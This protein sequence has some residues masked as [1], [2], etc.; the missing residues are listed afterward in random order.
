VKYDAVIVGSGPAGSVTAYYAA[1]N[2]ANVLICERRAE[3]GAPVLCGE[4]IS[5]QIDDF[6]MLRGTRRWIANNMDGAHVYSPD[7]TRVTL[8]AEK[9]GNETGYVIYRE[10]F[11]QTL[12]QKAVHAGADIMM[13][14]QVTGLLKENGKITGVKA[15]QFG[16]ELTI[17]ADVVVGADGVD[18]K[19]GLWAGIPTTLKTMDLETCAQHTLSNV[20]VDKAYCEFYLGKQI[21]PGGYIW[22]FPKGDDIAN[23]GIGVLAS[24]H[25]A[26]NA[27]Q[28][29]DQFI[30]AHPNL[31]KGRPFRFLAGAVPVALPIESVADNLLLVG[32]AA[33][34]VDPITGGGLTTSLQGGQ[35]AGETIAQAI[36]KKQFD[37]ETLSVYE[38]RWKEAFLRKLKRNYVVKEIFLDFDDK[39]I[40]MLADSLK[41]YNFDEINTLG[42]VKALVSK[43]PT[44]LMKLKPL[45]KVS[46]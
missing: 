6:E 23:V 33:R 29:L 39:T 5:K 16:K 44:L 8:A 25:E 1:K 2:G 17:N 12:A 11:D 19:V 27:K 20:E 24:L 40:N 46:K 21:A 28:L 13:N 32:D 37:R 26:G 31:K 42:L 9:A 30:D 15:Q 35:F 45:L 22:V 41:D 18:S 4:G 3:V 43:H 38:T 36:E 7:G 10:I 14:T 34:H